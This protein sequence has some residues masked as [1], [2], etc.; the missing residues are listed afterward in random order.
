MTTTKTSHTILA[1]AGRFFLTA[2][3]LASGFGKIGDFAGT[4]AY[5]AAQGMP[6]VSFFLA[7]AIALEI[8]GGLSLLLGYRAR[9][10]A[11]AL[12]LFLIPASVIFH[13]FWA[14][15]EA[16]AK[17]QMIMFMKNMAIFGALTQILVRGAGPGSL[18]A[19]AGR[20]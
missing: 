11:L 14:V 18:D 2:I 20:A 7:G 16:A 9:W 1:I 19:K 12:I 6:M 13:A 10:G 3:F 5:M 8:V 15:P 4:S 17:M